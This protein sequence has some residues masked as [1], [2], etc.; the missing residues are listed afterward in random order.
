MEFLIEKGLLH[1]LNKHLSDSFTNIQDDFF[2]NQTNSSEDSFLMKVYS[3]IEKDNFKKMNKIQL[4]WISCFL[5][6]KKMSL[7][8]KSVAFLLY[9]SL[10][11]FSSSLSSRVCVC[12]C[13]YI[14]IYTHTCTDKYSY[15]S[16]RIL[17]VLWRKSWTTT[18]L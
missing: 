18:S 12:I 8:G 2:T 17:E 6:W 9:D 16:G 5:D 14:Y 15:C 13:I 7:K 3:R 4:D 10:V 11:V 1:N